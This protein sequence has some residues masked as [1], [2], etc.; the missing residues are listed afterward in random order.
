[1]RLASL[2]VAIA[3]VRN[4]LSAFGVDCLEGGQVPVFGVSGLGESDSQTFVLDDAAENDSTGVNN[5]L[6]GLRVVWSE[7]NELLALENEMNEEEGGEGGERNFTREVTGSSSTRL[8]R[9]PQ[10]R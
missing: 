10:R 1:M 4:E 8:P 5:V 7:R 6:E 2:G 9:Q 3:R